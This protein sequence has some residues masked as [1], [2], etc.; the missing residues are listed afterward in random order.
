MA[1]VYFHALSS[2][3]MIFALMAVGFVLGK[4]GWMTA[5]D[6][7][8]ISRYVVNIAVPMNCISGLLNNFT[9]S[10]LKGMGSCLAVPFIT[11]VASLLISISA[12]K[13]LRLP[14]KKFGVF[15]AMSF[16]SNTLFIGLPLSTQLFGEVSVGYVML[17]Y[18]CG[19]I[20]T[21][22]VCVMLVEHSGTAAP[23]DHSAAGFFK[24]IFSKP[25]IIGLLAAVT[26]LLLDVRPP[27]VFMSFAKYLSNTVSPLALMYCGFVV[28]ELGIRNIRMER[29]I[30]VMLVIRLFVAPVICALACMLM[31][32]QGLCRNVFI[33]E[34][35]LP[36]VSS[37]TV[38]AGAYG[39]DEE[40]SATG[41]I[42]SMLGIF[43][44][45]PVL[46]VILT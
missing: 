8:F 9:R 17:Y 28:Y 19:T 11:I 29:G 27:D 44:T 10:D 16:L 15:V 23:K 1:S 20:F 46:M 45:I 26:M 36:T 14:K 40:Y 5:S 37:I 4:L 34:A 38:M 30:P 3:F 32:V 33:V 22:T 42:L 24:D 12:G 13:L 21:Q 35:A 2:V 6:K 25:P 31:G 18:V 39:A 43:I 41:S 7:K